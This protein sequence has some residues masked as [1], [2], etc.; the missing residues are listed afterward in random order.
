MYYYIGD[1]G[2]AGDQQ[3][4]RNIALTKPYPMC[5]SRHSLYYCRGNLV[6]QCAVVYLESCTGVG[7]GQI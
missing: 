3:V 7:G 2:T 6:H 1:L 4:N 5:I